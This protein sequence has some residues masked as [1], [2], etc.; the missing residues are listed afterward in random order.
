LSDLPIAF[1]RKGVAV[2]ALVITS[3]ALATFLLLQ[4]LSNTDG[5][6]SVLIGNE[7]GATRE[8]VIT[9]GTIDRIAAGENI[10]VLP[11]SM[12][13]RVGQ[14]IRIRNEDTKGSIVG[15]Y[16]VDANSVMTQRFTSAGT[17]SGLCSVHPSG[18]LTLTVHE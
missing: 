3:V 16:Y 5:P 8:Y 18:R 17:Y 6:G 9:A 10:E 11:A 12:E 7:E 1:T 13:F 4:T 15:P 14:S 2:L